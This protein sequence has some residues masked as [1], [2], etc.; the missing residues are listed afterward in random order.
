M[1]QGG[2]FGLHYDINCKLV[3][4][5]WPWVFFWDFRVPSSF[6]H[7]VWYNCEFYLQY[8]DLLVACKVCKAVI[9]CQIFW[10]TYLMSACYSVKYYS[11]SLKINTVLHSVCSKRLTSLYYLNVTTIM[12]NYYKYIWHLYTVM[13]QWILQFS[14]KLLKR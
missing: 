1:L 9:I 6:R 3:L 4:S 12:I 7:L 13:T 10:E 14:K 5:F 2:F 8:R 11:Q